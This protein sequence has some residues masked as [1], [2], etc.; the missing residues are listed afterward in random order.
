MHEILTRSLGFESKGVEEKKVPTA[1]RFTLKVMANI[2]LGP[3]NGQLETSTKTV[4]QDRS[5]LHRDFGK[6]GRPSGKVP[7]FEQT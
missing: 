3:A 5:P 6:F 4:H 7:D 1:L 2:H